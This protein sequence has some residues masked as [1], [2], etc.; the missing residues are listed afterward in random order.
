MADNLVVT[1]KTSE[2]LEKVTPES[3]EVMQEMEAYA[4]EHGFPIVGP[5]VGRLLYQLA[6]VSGAR[7]VVELGSGFGYS[8]YWFALAMGDKGE[9]VLTDG[10]PE[11][12]KRALDYFERA[13]LKSRFDFR[14]GDALTETAGL[15]APFDI[16]FCDIDKEGYPD[17]IKPA[18]G[19]LRRGG[20]F[21]IDNLLWDE[22]VCEPNPDDTTQAILNFTRNLYADDRFFTTIVPIRDGVGVAVRV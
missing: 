4:R 21:I 10:N 7:R 20:L 2:Y 13:G 1:K 17:T 19:W 16:V 15:S 12:K 22:K 6:F 5:Q 18:A 14:V 3:P 11:N 9:I 8:A